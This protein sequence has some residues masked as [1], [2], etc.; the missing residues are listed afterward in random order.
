MSHMRFTIT[1][2][3]P[4]KTK[5]KDEEKEEGKGKQVEK[6]EVEDTVDTSNKWRAF[7]FRGKKTYFARTKERLWDKIKE[8]VNGERHWRRRNRWIVKVE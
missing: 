4:K 1:R 8:D 5:N 3:K 2:L 7:S 6:E